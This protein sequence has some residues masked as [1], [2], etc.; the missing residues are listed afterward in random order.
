MEKSDKIHHPIHELLEKRWS[1]RAFDPEKTISDDQIKILFEA[2]RWTPS[3]SNLQPWRYVYAKREDQGFEDLFNCLD[4][5][6]R[7]W[8]KN[9][10]LLIVGIHRKDNPKRDRGNRHST[11]DLGQANFALVMQ[12]TAMGLYAHQMAGF[13]V[14]STNE[15][16]QLPNNFEAFTCIALG[17]MGD[18]EAL[19]ED[20]QKREVGRK[21]RIV[22]EEF[23]KPFKKG[24]AYRFEEG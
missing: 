8:V 4:E 5:G 23:A 21:E 24:K 12:A 7:R 14:K 16:L 11:H 2:A 1:P 3:S 9:A 18:K 6:N 13:S 20:L 15:L 22:Q 19:P 10:S 17:Y